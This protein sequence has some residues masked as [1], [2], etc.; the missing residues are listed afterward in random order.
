MLRRLRRQSLKRKSER[1]DRQKGENHVVVDFYS[2]PA[3]QACQG[4][5]VASKDNTSETDGGC[6]Q[7]GHQSHYGRN[8]KAFRFYAAVSP[9]GYSRISLFTDEE[10]EMY[11]E[12]GVV[13]NGHGSYWKGPDGKIFRYQQIAEGMWR[14]FLAE[15]RDDDVHVMNEVS[16]EDWKQLENSG[17]NDLGVEVAQSKLEIQAKL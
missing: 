16:L 17:H 14:A 1:S 13:E 15:E 6:V 11:P 5:E 10:R 7:V 8:R 2:L 4:E 9:G 12:I 3:S